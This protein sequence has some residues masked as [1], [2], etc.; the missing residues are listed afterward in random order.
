MSTTAKNL[1]RAR[2]HIRIRSKI[3]GTK[4]RPRLVV[5]RSLQHNYAQLIDDESGQCLANSSDMKA[6]TGTK[7]D[8]ASKVGED[9]A[10]KALEKNITTC[11]FDRNGYK[12]HGRVKQIADGART[13]GLKF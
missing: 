1:K 13:A 2:R 7:K 3:S 12:Y 9:L 4:D 6:K 10:K 5:Y 11:V 8:K